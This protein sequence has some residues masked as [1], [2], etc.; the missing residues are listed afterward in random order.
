MLPRSQPKFAHETHYPGDLRSVHLGF[1]DQFYLKSMDALLPPR[2]S[3]GVL[4]SLKEHHAH[5]LAPPKR[6]PAGGFDFYGLPGNKGQPFFDVVVNCAGFRADLSFLPEAARPT[7]KYPDTTP[8]FESTK[9][10]GI[11]FV[12]SLMHGR[13]RGAS[14]GG[15]I[16][17]FRYLTR[18]VVACPRAPRPL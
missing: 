13:D 15:F 8:W 16:H 12:G 9:M 2:Y 11:F 18:T 5:T 14:S 17:G 6:P 4:P 7:R 1:L 3:D 10:P